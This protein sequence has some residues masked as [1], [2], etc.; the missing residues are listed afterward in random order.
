MPNYKAAALA[1]HE[2]L[3]SRFQSFRLSDSM[4][5]ELR[6]VGNLPRAATL[7]SA[8]D[9]AMT[10]DGISIPEGAIEVTPEK[11]HQISY[12]LNLFVKA[13]PETASCEDDSGYRDTI[14]SYGCTRNF[15]TGPGATAADAIAATCGYEAPAPIAGLRINREDVYNNMH[16]AL[17]KVADSSITSVAWNAM[18][19][20]NADARDWMANIVV[21]ALTAPSLVTDEDVV[22][23]VKEGFQTDEVWSGLPDRALIHC[24]FDMFSD[25]DWRSLVSYFIIWPNEVKNAASTAGAELQRSD[26]TA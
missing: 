25:A 19:V 11:A 2:Y 24:I 16:V 13:A 10:E 22:K 12:L 8:V 17:R 15:K 14:Y 9:A 26:D 4:R 6:F 18:H 7:R 21:K 5:F 20:I 23:A 3:L 1:R